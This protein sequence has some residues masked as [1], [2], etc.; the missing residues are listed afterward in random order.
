MSGEL[1]VL[2]TESQRPSWSKEDAIV[3]MEPR[4]LDEELSRSLVEGVGFSPLSHFTAGG[5][6]GGGNKCQ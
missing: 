5:G 3:E 4:R 1:V 2:E 6:G